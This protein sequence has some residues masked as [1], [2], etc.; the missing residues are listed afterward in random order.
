[1]IDLARDAPHLLVGGVPGGGK[2]EWLRCA[3]A[4]LLL[5][6]SP[7]RLRLVVIDPKKNAFADLVRSAYLWRANSLVDTPEG[8][9]IPLLEDLIA[10]M[11]KRYD[12]FKRERT[13]DLAQYAAKTGTVLPRL[14]CVVDE[15]ADLL[16]GSKKAEREEMEGGFIRIAQ[17]GR[18][19]GVHL[20]LATQR[21][22]RQVVSGLLKAN[23]PAR[24]A[25]QVANR[26]ESGVLLDQSGAQY[27]L[28]K[29]DLLLSSGGREPIRLQSAWMTDQ[30]RETLFGG[31][32][33][34]SSGS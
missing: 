4:S 2:S 12:A 24:I 28:G 29:G 11:G 20:I 15:F 23:I 19:A 6:N 1:M 8:A 17:I 25:L 26:V 27:L 9:V 32:R 5:T 13:D 18:A 33:A 10:E 16:M 34:A 22:S 7:D 30:D 3:V 21:P 14:V 31:S